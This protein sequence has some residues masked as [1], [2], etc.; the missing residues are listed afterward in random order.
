MVQEAGAGAGNGVERLERGTLRLWEVIVGGLSQAA[1]ALSLYF[2]TAILAG[3]AGFGIPLVYLVA[4]GAIVLTAW[5]A[6][7]FAGHF[8]S[9]GSMVT[10]VSN[11]IGP[12]AGIWT[13]LLTQFGYL[14]IISS[15][16]VLWGLWISELLMRWFGVDIPWQLIMVL[17]AAAFLALMI[18][19]IQVSMIATAIL[20][21]FEFIVIFVLATIIVLQGGA[22]GNTAQPF[23]L[24]PDGMSG[25]WLGFVFA[26]FSYVGWEG[27]LSLAEEARDPR[28]AMPIAP[29]FN[30][31]V[32]G[33]LY[34]FATYAAVIGFGV[35]NMDALAGDSAPF[36]TL[37]QQYT[38]A[39]RAFVD[40]AGATSIAAS[41]LAATN[42]MARVL[43]NMGREGMIPRVLGKV[44]PRFKTPYIALTFYVAFSVIICGVWGM[45]QEPLSV[46][47][48][49]SGLGAIA[50]I[51]GYML[52]N[53][54]L[55]V[56]VSRNPSKFPRRWLYT[57]VPAV[58]VIVLAFP[59]YQVTNPV[60]QS[61]PF[62]TFWLVILIVAI[63]A[64]VYTQLLVRSRPE[65]TREAGSILA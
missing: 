55:I 21:A 19:G 4:L 51:P 61:F 38:P 2:T 65:I 3:V 26:V 17:G 41:A 47:G 57:I 32:L 35:N 16:Y 36:D 56:Y 8:P 7:R 10:L 24:G 48:G 22:E 49:V 53:I 1:P 54:A 30:I 45:F 58:G 23:T 11:G 15:V 28:H 18:I 13:G 63:V 40:I 50:V 42:N 12:R 64:A 5:S 6:G 14:L 9:A 29:I 31:L 60:G 25:L 62:N 37:A 43:F 33:G 39:L 52:I 34:V 20:F 44:H 27:S 59:L 46:F